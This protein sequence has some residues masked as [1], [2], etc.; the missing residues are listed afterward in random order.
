[1]AYPVG[2]TPVGGMAVSADGALYVTLGGALPAA[3]FPLLAP[4]GS[5]A[6]PSYSFAS[7]TN[8]GM[9]Y[10]AGN[11]AFVVGGQADIQITSGHVTQVRT[12]DFFSG[13][14]FISR[15]GA[16]SIQYSATNAAAAATSRNEINKAV[17]SIA[18]AT[19]TATF[20]IT[21]PNA[22]H[23]ASILIRMTGSLGAGG[24]IGANEA[25]ASNS[26]VITLTRTAGVN[27]VAAIS[28]AFGAAA[29]AVAGAATVT[30]TA[31]MSTVSGA[32]GAVNTF[33]VNVT[34]TRSGGS[35]TNHTCLCFA[36][37]M[38]ANASGIT[39]S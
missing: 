9:F 37:L 5:G 10:N 38:N 36:Q 16:N 21:V 23:S 3:A 17:A 34:I 8:M 31:A 18:D 13:D 32:V 4:D 26:Y 15:L 19:P 33:T 25:S 29:T 27:A 35:S 2:S 24:A 6:A 39:I 20:T 14:A 30:C 12:L 28:S 1:M 22:A 7:A 11:L